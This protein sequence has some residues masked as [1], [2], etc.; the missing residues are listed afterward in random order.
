[1]NTYRNPAEQRLGR[2]KAEL[3]YSDVQSIINLGLHE[4]IDG[5]Q[6]KL[7]EVAT[8]IHDTFF[9]MRPVGSTQTQMQSR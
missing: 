1:M 7:N 9:A 3:A 5:L 4:F 6:I 8:A 2:L